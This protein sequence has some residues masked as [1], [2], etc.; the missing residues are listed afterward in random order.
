MN[1]IINVVRRRSEFNKYHHHHQILHKQKLMLING[2]LHQ[3]F[4]RQTLTSGINCA[5]KGTEHHKEDKMS[6]PEANRKRRNPH[7]FSSQVI[8]HDFV[9]E[10][11]ETSQPKPG[12]SVKPNI[13]DKKRSVNFHPT[14]NS[15]VWNKN[16]L[17]SGFSL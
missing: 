15:P 2:K 17:F 14:F 10:A 13:L 16:R 4:Q 8:K 7:L 12:F 5:F 1:V 6:S 9:H 11:V 3:I